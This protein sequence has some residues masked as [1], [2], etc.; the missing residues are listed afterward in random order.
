MSNTTLPGL[1]RLSDL[2][3]PDEMI[4]L[5]P[6]PA[7]KALPPNPRRNA[8]MRLPRESHAAERPEREEGRVELLQPSRATV[9]AVVTAAAMIALA[10]GHVAEKERRAL[11]RFLR[12][13]GVLER[14]GRREVLATF[15][16]ALRGVAPLD[17][18]ETCEAADRLRPVASL[19]GARLVAQAAAVVVLADGVAWPQ[20]IALLEVI[21]E[22]VGLGGARRGEDVR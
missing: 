7:A 21:R 2:S 3:S 12:S 14:H 19:P 15:E 10:D 16:A 5:G 22:R 4:R 18:A 9:E 17:L 13:A 8:L 1:R 6:L 20:E 11:L